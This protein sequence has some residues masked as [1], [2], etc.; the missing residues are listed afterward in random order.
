MPP[1]LA[2]AALFLLVF[3]L[4][5]LVWMPAAMLDAALRQATA[6]RL[7]L[8]SAQGT[9][10]R[11]EGDLL[12]LHEHRFLSLGHYLWHVSPRFDSAA[13][14]VRLEDGRQAVTVLA[15]H[16]LRRELTLERLQLT[17]P[18][19]LLPLFAPQLTLYRLGGGMQL[20]GGPCT[21]RAGHYQGTAQLDWRQ[22]SSALTE[23]NPLGDYRITMRGAGDTLGL[24]L[25][26]LQGK[27]VLQGDG[28][29]TADGRL[30]FNGTA[31]AAAG[32]EQ[33]LSEL[34]HHIG[35]EQSPGQFSFA[36]A[37]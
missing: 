17:L 16:P 15:V 1:R 29:I 11:G 2:Q 5:L 14:E 32:Q 6:G 18:A 37:Q 33:A 10:W 36:L 25:T 21:L 7:S 22:A 27:L 8:A 4:A 35:P 28:R 30:D 23:L 26:T 9:L 3:L 19:Q 34:L 13:L 20:T 12:L 24:T 31:R